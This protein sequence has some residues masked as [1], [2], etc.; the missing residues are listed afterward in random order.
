MYSKYRFF[1]TNTSGNYLRQVFP[2]YGD[3]TSLIHTLEKEQQL[4]RTSLD[5]EFK[6]LKADF[7]FIM[8]MPF[9]STIYITVERSV[10]FGKRYSTY[11]KGKFVR[12]DCVINEID[13]ILKVSITPVDGYENIISGLDKEFDLI[14][15]APDMESIYLHKRPAIQVYIDGDSVLTSFIGGTYFEQSVSPV[16]VNNGEG[17]IGGVLTDMGFAF[18]KTLDT[19]TLRATSQGLQDATGV[20]VGFGSDSSDITNSKIGGGDFKFRWYTA[21]GSEYDVQTVAE[22]IYIPTGEIVGIIESEKFGSGQVFLPNTEYT[23]TAKSS[24]GSVLYY[25]S[26]T[27]TYIYARLLLD[28]DYYDGKKT[29]DIPFEDIANNNMNYKKCVPVYVQ[30]HIYLSSVISQSPTEWGLYQPGQYFTKPSISLTEQLYPIGKSMWIN[31]SLWFTPILPDGSLMYSGGKK[32]LLKH[33]YTLAGCIKVLLAKVAPELTFDESSLYS[34]F[35]YETDN[36]ISHDKFRLFIVPITNITKGEYDQPAQKA[37][38]TLRNIFDMLKACYRCYWFIDRGRLRIE[39]VSFF[40][41]GLNYLALADAGIDVSNIIEPKTEKP[42]TTA[43]NSYHFD[44]LNIPEYMQFK[45]ADSVSKPFAGYSIEIMSNYVEKGN[46]EEVNVQKFSSDVD[47]ML[48]NPESFSKDNF[49]L[50]A[51]VSTDDAYELPFVNS[52]V[53]G[54]KYSLQNGLLSF[55]DLHEKYYKLDLPANKV[56]INGKG[57]VASN[58]HV[59]RSKIQEIKFPVGI[60]QINPMQLIRTKLGDGLADSISIN[61]SSQIANVTLRYDN[62]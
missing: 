55:I 15:L 13:K 51:A 24:G 6:F 19:I 56:K 38:I 25:W 59:K 2:L 34:R 44:K 49:A 30:D 27:E 58:N 47:L 48:L 3:K 11:F 29:L 4:Y 10:D 62:E 60:S 32:Y 45:W 36:P 52:E 20:Y 43:A 40:R 54:Y 22:L 21:P 33:A 5:G 1:I 39:H 7:D 46:V 18:Q 31:A 57:Y 35:F 9:D 8:S 12:T 41:N 28:E 37:L 50:L 14:E 17:N 16:N 42:W 26:F 61:L 23:L 53:M